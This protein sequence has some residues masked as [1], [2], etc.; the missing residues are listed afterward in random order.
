V[1][2]KETP[3]WQKRL[4]NIRE[5]LHEQVKD[6][7]GDDYKNVL[8]ELA[9]DIEGRLEAYDVENGEDDG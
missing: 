4:E 7:T 6:L 1:A 5:Y 2:K 9:T 3:E 8:E